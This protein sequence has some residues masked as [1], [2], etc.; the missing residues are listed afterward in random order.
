MILYVVVSVI[1]GS[2]IFLAPCD[3]SQ[4]PGTGDSGQQSV[5][6]WSTS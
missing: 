1:E 3:G 2:V 5:P 4:S 6:V